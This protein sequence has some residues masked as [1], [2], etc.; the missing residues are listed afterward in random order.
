MWIVHSDGVRRMSSGCVWALADNTIPRGSAPRH[1]LLRYGERRT[2]S[3]GYLHSI[4]PAAH[5]VTLE[6][7]YLSLSALNA[8]CA[9][10][11]VKRRMQDHR[12]IRNIFE[13]MQGKCG[14]ST[15]VLSRCADIIA[16][17]CFQNTVIQQQ[18]YECG[19]HLLLVKLLQRA[20]QPAGDL[21]RCMHR[22]CCALLSHLL[23]TSIAVSG[24]RLTKIK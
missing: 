9:D 22:F 16:V 2:P 10:T 1:L 12:G 5:N 21:L 23:Q 17:V 18:A 8:L 14:G 15:T 4:E 11:A 24:N 20:C 13:V 19:G 3:N 7:T 6:T